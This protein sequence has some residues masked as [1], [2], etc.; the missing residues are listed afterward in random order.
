M[1]YHRP[2]KRVHS[3]SGGRRRGSSDKRLS[4]YGGFFSRGKYDR[5][6][7]EEKREN[8]RTKGGTEKTSAKVALFANITTPQGT[9][10]AKI[11]NVADNPSNRHYARENIITKGALI[12]TELGRAR[13]TSRPG[14]AGVV[15][16]VL[17]KE[18]Q[19][20]AA[21]AK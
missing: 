4:Q 7:K 14:Q 3:G 2:V 13:V 19:A 9:K 6:A 1:L 15:N 17:L 11:T 8:R 10:K 18:Q 21:R 12:E 16:A 20:Q 5:E